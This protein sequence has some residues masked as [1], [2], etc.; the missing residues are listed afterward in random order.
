MCKPKYATLKRLTNVSYAT[1][2]IDENDVLC[3]K[4]QFLA[5]KKN[6]TS[7]KESLNVDR[8]RKQSRVLSGLWGKHTNGKQRKME[9]FTAKELPS[10]E[11]SVTLPYDNY[12]RSRRIGPGLYK[13]KLQIL[14]DNMNLQG[15]PRWSVCDLRTIPFRNKL[16]AFKRK[17]CVNFRRKSSYHKLMKKW[18]IKSRF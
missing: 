12:L 10:N 1:Q 7:V 4:I 16:M 15:E 2:N 18:R 17:K 3:R 13:R 5:K 11:N 14:H 9:N 8:M 6:I